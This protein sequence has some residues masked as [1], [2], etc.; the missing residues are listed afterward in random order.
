MSDEIWKKIYIDDELSIYDISNY[1]KVRNRKT[2]QIRSSTSHT[3]Y[4]SC[5]LVHKDKNINQLV[6]RL[7][8]K[9]FIPNNTDKK[10]VNHIDG[11][12]LN[13]HVSN[14]EWV[15]SIENKHI[16]KNVNQKS[17]NVPIIR[18]N[19]DKTNP[20]RYESVSTALKEYGSYVSLCLSGQAK[21]AYG[22]I[23]TYENPIDK[24]EIDLTGYKQIDG[25]PNFLISI[26]GKVYNK[27]KNNF[28]LPKKTD[29]YMS[30]VLNKKQFCLHRLL[31]IHFLD[32]PENYNEKR[33]VNHKDGNKLN[34]NI[35][36]LEWIFASDNMHHT[37]E[38]GARNTKIIIQKDLDGNL[39]QEHLNAINASKMLNLGRNVNS[40][41][42]RACK[43]KEKSIVFGYRWEYKS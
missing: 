12:K 25:Y 23:W 20:V 9:T 26:D 32:K 29:S 1:G 3:G 42:L 22:Y 24:T 28:L 17:V 4:K 19:I 43:N 6:H 10:Y 38:S 13:N 41:I 30:V 14:L 34:N 16:H 37:Y 39:I 15:T 31:A 27:S 33:I 40:Q 21:Q 18:W 5:T 36:N 7:V 2:L 11:D 35:D 8:A